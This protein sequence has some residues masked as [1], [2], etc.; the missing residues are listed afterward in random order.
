MFASCEFFYRSATDTRQ[1]Q[2]C[3]WLVLKADIWFQLQKQSSFLEFS[4]KA[5]C[6]LIEPHLID[7]FNG[8]IT[9]KS[10]FQHVFFYPQGISHTLHIYTAADAASDLIGQSWL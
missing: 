4:G 5:P 10:S 6:L 8:G 3:L 2:Y 9:W 1:L 7:I